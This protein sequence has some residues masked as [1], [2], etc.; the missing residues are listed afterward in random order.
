M[1]LKDLQQTYLLIG[2]AARRSHVQAA[3]AEGKKAPYLG[4]KGVGR[5]SA[6]RLGSQLFV[7]TARKED[8][9]LNTLEVDWN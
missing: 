1:S 7:S 5:L 6:M 4:E 9:Y 8:K 2:T 3:I